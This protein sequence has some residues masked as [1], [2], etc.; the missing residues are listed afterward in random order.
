MPGAARKP[1]GEPMSLHLL[2]ITPGEGFRPE[3][4]APVLASGIDGFL[5]REPHLS[6][7]TLHAAATWCRTEHPEVALWVRGL[8]GAAW[9]LHLPESA[10]SGADLRGASAPLHHPDQWPERQSAAQLLVSPIF[11]TPGKGPAWGPCALRRFLDAL[12]GEGPRLLALGGIAPARAQELRH[13]R[14]SGIAAIRPFWGGDPQA[15]VSAFR[16]AWG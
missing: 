5:I 16:T 9:G 14:L 3:A 4:W 2:A 10:L 6:P 13:S 11:E 1:E 8:A 7:E 12:P 15:A